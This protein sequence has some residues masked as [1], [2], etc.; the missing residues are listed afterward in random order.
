MVNID[1]ILLKN[2]DK[3]F[4]FYQFFT[5]PVGTS[6]QNGEFG[7][8]GGSASEALQPE[9]GAF[10]DTVQGIVGSETERL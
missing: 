8:N 7:G 5:N 6:L 9:H 10:A 3:T 1:S 4:D 2:L